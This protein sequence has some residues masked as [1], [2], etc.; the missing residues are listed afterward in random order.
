M[1]EIEYDANVVN[2]H[3][4]NRQ[5]RAR[6]GAE[7]HVRARLFELVL[8]RKLHRG[9][10]RGHFAH[11]ID[12][13]VPDLHVVDLERVVETILTRPELHVRRVERAG[14]SDCPFAQIDRR[15]FFSGFKRCG[16]NCTNTGCAGARDGG[17]GVI[18]GDGINTDP[19]VCL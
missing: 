1:A 11:A 13:V 19:P 5:E 10:R 7:E 8:N 4:L 3:L 9:V 2:A 14:D 16:H 12:G 17:R 18:A 6:R 15:G